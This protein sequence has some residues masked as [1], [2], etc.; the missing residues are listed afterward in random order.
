MT[1]EIDI[2]SKDIVDPGGNIER[3]QGWPSA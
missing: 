2:G 1:G 3:T